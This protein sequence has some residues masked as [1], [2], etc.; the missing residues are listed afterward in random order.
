MPDG[1]CLLAHSELVFGCS[2]DSDD[3]CWSTDSVVEVGEVRMTSTCPRC[4][5]TDIK[6][7]T[8][9]TSGKAIALCM[10]CRENFIISRDD[11]Q[12]LVLT[13]MSQKKDAR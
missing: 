3:H 12:T 13:E 5:S 2:V 10:R 4:G 9:A 11:H 8:R 6:I 7:L 1:V